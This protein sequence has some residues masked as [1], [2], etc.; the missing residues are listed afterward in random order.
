MFTGLIQDVGTVERVVAGPM[1]ELWIRSALGVSSFEHGESVAVNGACLTVV[2]RQ[3][4]TFKV[5]AA[6]ESLRRT[7]LGALAP[8]DKVNLERALRVGDRLGGHLV[9]GH[10]DAVTQVLE[11]RVEGGSLVLTFCLPAS[12]AAY[13]IDKGSVTVDGTSL[14]VMH[15]EPE[16]F[17]VMLIPETQQATTLGAR[18]VGD[19]VNLEADMIGKY[20]ARLFSLGQLPGGGQGQQ[21]GGGITRE[22]IAAAGFAAHKR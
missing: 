18:Q 13:F 2:D 15:V 20:V 14:T 4:D 7:T 17:C 11:R 6:P 10:V 21:P 22:T 8:R 9:Q 16:R 12:L 3:G 5:Q 1:T 19:R